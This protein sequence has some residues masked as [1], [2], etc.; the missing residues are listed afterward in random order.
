MSII[1]LISTGRSPHSQENVPGCRTRCGQDHRTVTNT[2]SSLG[3]VRSINLS[4]SVLSSII[5]LFSHS[6][7]WTDLPHPA[8][9]FV[10]DPRGCCSYDAYAQRFE[11]GFTV[12]GYC[13]TEYL[14]LNI[15]I[16]KEG[17]PAS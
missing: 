7:Q 15:S 14:D 2:A 17:P 13:T 8:W 4:T 12:R 5:K 11:Q 16:N 1:A 10:K 6:L 3:I 9:V